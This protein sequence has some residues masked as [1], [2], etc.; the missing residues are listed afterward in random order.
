MRSCDATSASRH[1]GGRPTRLEHDTAKELKPSH[2][3]DADGMT[4]Q[5]VSVRPLGPEESDDFD[6]I[7]EVNWCAGPTQA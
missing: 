6:A 5:V 4:Y 7:V 1:P 2:Y 3:I